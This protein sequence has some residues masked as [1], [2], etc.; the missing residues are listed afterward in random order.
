MH[1]LLPYLAV[2]VSEH[3]EEE[4]EEEKDDDDDEEEDDFPFVV[5]RIY[6]RQLA[7]GDL[8]PVTL[9]ETIVV[10]FL[11][12]FGVT[13]NSAIIG[14]IAGVIAN[15]ETN[16]QRYASRMELVNAFLKSHDVPRELQRRIQG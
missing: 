5:Y 4:K 11:I 6:D 9:S 13:L 12:I 8:I 14:E 15:L 16:Q 2:S 3:D 1:S 7:L 10:I